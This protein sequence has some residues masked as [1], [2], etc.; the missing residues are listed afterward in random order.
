MRKLILALFMACLIPT[1]ATA[2]AVHARLIGTDG[3]ATTGAYL[4]A[5]LLGCSASQGPVTVNGAVGLVVQTTVK[6]TPSTTGVVM[7]YLIG[8]DQ[9]LCGGTPNTTSWRVTSFNG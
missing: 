5:T 1:L 2:T 9:L 4:Q 3:R 6:L 7:N 8:N